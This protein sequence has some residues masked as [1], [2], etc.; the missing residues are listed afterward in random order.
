MLM[1]PMRLSGRS[2]GCVGVVPI[3][4]STSSPLI[5]LPKVV[6][7]WSKKVGA[8]WQMKNC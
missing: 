6:Y 5:N 2:C 3:F 7:W 8:P 4:S 1:M